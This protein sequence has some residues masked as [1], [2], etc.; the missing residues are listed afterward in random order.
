MVLP[1][2]CVGVV[3]ED[4][5]QDNQ[6]LEDIEEDRPDGQTLRGLALLPKLDVVLESKELEDTEIKR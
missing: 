2:D 6:V 4:V 3:I 1:D 5:E